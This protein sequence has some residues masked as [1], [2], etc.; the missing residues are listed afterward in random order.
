[1]CI[2]LL[3]STAEV[4]TCICLLSRREDSIPSSQSAEMIKDPAEPQ[5]VSRTLF[6][7]VYSV[8]LVWYHR[9]SLSSS[10]RI[11]RPEQLVFSSLYYKCVTIDFVLL[12][13]C[14]P[15][16]TYVG[17]QGRWALSPWWLRFSVL[18]LQAQ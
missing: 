10:D 7:C 18:K 6:G 12:T 15:C 3:V 14:Q 4:L 1:M 2:L 13:C 5:F 17:K 11:F 8:C 9:L 16:N